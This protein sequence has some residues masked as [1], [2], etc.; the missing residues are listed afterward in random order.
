MHDV[1]RFFCSSCSRNC[2][3]AR[4]TFAG[5]RKQIQSAKPYSGYP[6]GSRRPG[7][8]P[9]HPGVT[10]GK[11]VVKQELEVAVITALVIMIAVDVLV[12]MVTDIVVT[13]SV[14][15]GIVYVKCNLPRTSQY[16]DIQ[17]N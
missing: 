9:T 11:L 12:A 10:S 15:L 1:L 5:D 3:S 16:F 6:K 2:F 14:K 4:V 17:P 13:L 7:G 8:D